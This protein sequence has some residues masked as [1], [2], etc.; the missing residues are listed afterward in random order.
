MNLNKDHVAYF[1]EAIQDML[2]QF[3]RAISGGASL[4]HLR[5][6]NKKLKIL[7]DAK[8]HFTYTNENYK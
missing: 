3:P 5:E 2:E 1:D 4:S 7:K 8:H 6:M